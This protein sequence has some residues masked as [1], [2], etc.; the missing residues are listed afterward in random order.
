MYF[1][2][3][4]ILVMFLL[5]GALAF[6]LSRKEPETDYS[7]FAQCLAGKDVVMYGA[8]WCSHCQNQK[9]AFGEAFK[10]VKYVECP[11]NIPLCTDKG[12]QGF[13]TWIF[14]NG[15]TLVGEQPLAKL[16]AES[17]CPLP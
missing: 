3:G 11:D 9:A 13:P 2:V 1:A 4:A 10:Y 6:S 14:P 16:A 15:V 8:A 12:I 5:A 7:A 17:G